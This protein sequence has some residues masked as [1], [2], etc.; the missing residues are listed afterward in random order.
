MPSKKN[1]MLYIILPVLA[2]MCASCTVERPIE[3]LFTPDQPPR[4]IAKA[5]MPGRFQDQAVAGPSTSTLES[6]MALSAK[7]TKLIEETTALKAENQ[8]LLEENLQL[9]DEFAPCITD[10]TQAQKELAEANDLLIEMRIEMSN[11]K[12][13][14][15]GFRDEMRNAENAQLDALVKILEV[16]GGQAKAETPIDPGI[17]PAI[18]SPQDPNQV[19]PA[20]QAATASK[21]ING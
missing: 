5:D 3:S 20:L 15:L 21:Q 12:T 16:L 4:T 2:L 8:K 1:N 9:K 7:Y 18:S 14:I 11:W 6:A 13:N 17:R 19:Q 10:L